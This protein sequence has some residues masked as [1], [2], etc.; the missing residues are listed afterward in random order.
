MVAQE[1]GVQCLG[2]EPGFMM[3]RDAQADDMTW[4]T[5]TWMTAYLRWTSNMNPVSSY[6]YNYW[7]IYYQWVLNANKILNNIDEVPRTDE[8]LY[9]QI[10]GEAL[11][12]RG[13]AYHN[14]VQLYGGRYVAGTSN[15]QLGIPYRVEANADPL[16]R[17]TVEE[18]YRLINEDLDQACQLLE[19]LDISLLTHYSDMV[20][21]GLK[22]RVAMAM[23]DYSNAATYAAKSIDLAETNHGRR[24]MSGNE[25]YCGFAK[26]TDETKEPMYSARTLDDQTDRKSVV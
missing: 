11:C 15:T 21:Y 6:N 20:A 8:A 17:S 16:A 25:L 13:W 10:K 12:I 26:I 22:A 3:C 23:Q 2:G 14:L 9:K 1:T 4:V 5:N 19:G 18:T 7:Q 24:L